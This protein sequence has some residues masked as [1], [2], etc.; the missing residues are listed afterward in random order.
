MGAGGQS[1][2]PVGVYILPFTW[3]DKKGNSLT[4]QHEI[5][6]MKELNSGAIMGMDFIRSLGIVYFNQ[7][8]TFHFESS[9]TDK[10]RPFEVGEIVTSQEMFL[11]AQSSQ[12]IKVSSKHPRR[13]QKARHCPQITSIAEIHCKDYKQIMGPQGVIILNHQAMFIVQ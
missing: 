3:T 9:W 12:A 4:V 2:Q 7:T 8:H 1:L 10:Q 6:V 11:P 5:V 13:I